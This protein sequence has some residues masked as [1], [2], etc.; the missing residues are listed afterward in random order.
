MDFIILIICAIVY[1]V[2]KSKEGH[3]TS[4]VRAEYARERMIHDIWMKR[5]TNPELERELK[6]MDYLT[7][8]KMA[9]LL[10][11]MRASGYP[12]PYGTGRIVHRDVVRIMLAK[13]GYLPYNDALGNDHI[14]WC[15]E[16]ER[17]VLLWCNDLL[18]ERNAPTRLVNGKCGM[19]KWEVMMQ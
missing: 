17:S 8:D 2:L 14:S 5:I 12:V 1:M 16:I 4:R 18:I 13:R 19:Y 9:A 6:K 3:Q 15:M 10:D 7:H 11:E